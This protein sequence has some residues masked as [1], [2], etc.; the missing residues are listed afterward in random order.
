MNFFDVKP[1]IVLRSHFFLMLAFLFYLNSCFW[2]FSLELF[3][4]DITLVHGSGV[5]KAVVP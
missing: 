3:K 4:N 2:I 1:K 5:K